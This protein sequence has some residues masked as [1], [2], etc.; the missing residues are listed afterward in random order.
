M[1]LEAIKKAHN[2]VVPWLY[3]GTELGD[4]VEFRRVRLTVAFGKYARDWQH[5]HGDK[6]SGN[7]R[8]KQKG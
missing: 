6:H 1:F 5:R 8:Y 3:T 7:N 2:M 4:G